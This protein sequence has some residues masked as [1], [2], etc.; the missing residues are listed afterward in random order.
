MQV[1]DYVEMVLTDLPK[2][3]KGRAATPAANHLFKVNKKNPMFLDD[4][5]REL[6]VKLV[7]Q[8]IYLSQ[9]AQPDLRTAISFLCGRTQTPDVYNYKKLGR[10]LKYLQSTKDLSLILSADGSGLLRWWVDA[11]YGVHMDM[12]GHTGGNMSMG[13]G[14]V[15]TTANKQKLVTR[16][17]TEC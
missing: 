11:S 2:E 15:Y 4:T 9:C 1:L 3:F 5:K 12:K 6:F 16:S 10:V 8:L 13:K 17:S 7:M 14:S